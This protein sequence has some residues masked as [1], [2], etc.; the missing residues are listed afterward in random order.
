MAFET[1]VQQRANERCLGTATE[2]CSE[3]TDAATVGPGPGMRIGPRVVMTFVRPW[4][5]ER[6]RS[7]CYAPVDIGAELTGTSTP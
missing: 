1:A 7:R 6:A 5:D 4:G 2:A 3:S